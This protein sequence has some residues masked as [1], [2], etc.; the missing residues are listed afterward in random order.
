[1]TGP[2]QSVS[3][4]A[5]QRRYTG[6]RLTLLKRQSLQTQSAVITPTVL[7]GEQGL[8]REPDIGPDDLTGRDHTQ[9]VVRA[10]LLHGVI[11]FSWRQVR[12]QGIAPVFDLHACERIV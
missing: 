7:Y 5:T 4:V 2:D 11:L 12:E 6:A 10:S 3:S 8:S 1:M 9:N